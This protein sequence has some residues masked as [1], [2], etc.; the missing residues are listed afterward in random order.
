MGSGKSAVART[1]ARRLR[2]PILD[3]DALIEEEIGCYIS[4][5][6]AERGEAEFRRIES[7]VLAQIAAQKGVVSLGGGVTTQP[8]TREILKK[9]AKNGATVVYL[10]AS[11]EILASR[12]RRQPGKRP[13]IDGDGELDW[14][15]TLARVEE[16]LA[17]REPLYRECANC[18]VDTDG[19]TIPAVSREI[20]SRMSEV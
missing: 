2:W 20:I 13:L 4:R 3:L 19:A 7:E 16:L 15:A 14:P 12:I 8:Q 6:F 10:R 11:P 17:H 1:L 18:V 5:F 9:A